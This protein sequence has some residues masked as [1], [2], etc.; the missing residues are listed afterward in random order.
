MLHIIKFIVIACIFLIPI[1]LQHILTFY[2]NVY[3]TIH[4]SIYGLYICVY[5][6][7]QILF[8]WINSSKMKS[9]LNEIAHDYCNILVVGYREDAEYFKMCLQSIRD[10]TSHSVNVNKVI[11]VI[12]GNEPEDQYMSD[13]FKRIFPSGISLQ[14]PDYTNTTIFGSMHS[15]QNNKYVC[16]SQ[17]HSSK[18]QAMHTGF[19]LSIFENETNRTG[20]IVKTVLCTDSDTV[21]DVN[22]IDNMLPIFSDPKV[23]AVA[24][25]LSIFTKYDSWISFM[26]TLRYWYAF[27]LERAYQS[28]SNYVVCISGPIGM[29]RLD[30][31]KTIMPQ[32]IQQT[33]LGKRCTFGDDRHLTNQILALDYKILYS[34]LACASTET[35]K[36]VIRFFRQQTR[37]SKSAYREFFWTLTKVKNQS[38]MMTI[39]IIYQ[40]FFPYFV[41]GYLLYVL[42][43]GTVY[44]FFMYTVILAISGLIKSVYGCIKNK[45]FEHLF[46]IIYAIPYI[47]IVFA[48]KLWALFTLAN[49]TWGTNN[50]KGVGSQSSL[51]ALDTAFLILWNCVLAGG[52]GMKIYHT[53]LSKSTLD[54]IL[55]SSSVGVGLFAF[56][57]VL[58]YTMIRR[59]THRNQH[60]K[61]F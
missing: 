10:L 18:R 57:L 14:L 40:L 27:N 22:C 1:I 32:W 9:K 20:Y 28:F 48:A 26:S 21:F 61:L 51:F 44:Q 50:R 60:K 43:W 17:P 35:P 2:D 34:P 59:S 56:C 13:I 16:I 52:L 7:V 58:V 49:T 42:Y 3:Q 6:L 41:M 33:F 15:V 4:L 5:T 54:I 55:M 23:G 46:Y 31:L 29:Y 30:L 47:T 25:N 11:V 8:S 36:T 39:D 45:T 19:Q 38:L 12:D 37:W 24:G 53:V